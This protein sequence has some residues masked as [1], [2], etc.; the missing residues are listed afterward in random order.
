MTQKENSILKFKKEEILD[1]KN[2]I[3]GNVLASNIKTPTGVS[4]RD[5]YPYWHPTPTSK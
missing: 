2:I 3:A 5:Y 1:P 4:T